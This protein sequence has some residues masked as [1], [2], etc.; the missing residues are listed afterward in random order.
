[1]LDTRV[2]LLALRDRTNP[3]QRRRD[4]RHPGSVHWQILLYGRVKLPTQPAAGGHRSRG[5]PLGT[6]AFANSRRWPMN[7]AAAAV[8]RPQRRM[9]KPAVSADRQSFDLPSRSTGYAL[10]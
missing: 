8:G 7:G 9:K 6:V 3:R 4:P 10:F 5:T 1:M 2:Q